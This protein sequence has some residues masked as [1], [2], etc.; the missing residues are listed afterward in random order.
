MNMLKLIGV[1]TRIS[2]YC[3]GY[4]GRDDYDDKTCV[5]VT[6]RYAVFENDEGKATVLNMYKG[7]DKDIDSGLF[8]G[9]DYEH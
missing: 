4:F 2:G 8:K 9:G 1:G 7:I 5:F 6:P 3:G